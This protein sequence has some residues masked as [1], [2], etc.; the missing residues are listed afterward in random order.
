MRFCRCAPLVLV[1]C[2]LMPRRVAVRQERQAADLDNPQIEPPIQISYRDKAVCKG[3]LMEA[4]PGT[5][6]AT[7]P[8]QR[9]WHNGEEASVHLVPC[10]YMDGVFV[11]V[12]QYCL[13][14]WP[15]Q[16]PRPVSV[17]LITTS[18][19]VDSDSD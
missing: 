8:L 7:Q 15:R 9:I 3:R 6:W 10:G 18:D 1:F 13:A 5:N 11:K 16:G 4:A 17:A 19:M 14:V 12:P 2:I